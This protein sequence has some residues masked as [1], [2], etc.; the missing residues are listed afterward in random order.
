MVD[1]KYIGLF[2]AMS[3]SLAIGASSIITKMGLN[4]AATQDRAYAS[5]NHA[6]LK[7]GIW[8]TGLSVLANFA[9][10]T[11]A[12]PILVTPLGSISV[13]TGAVL[14]SYILKEELG[15]LGRLGCTLCVIGSLIIVLHA[16]ADKDIQTVDDILRFAKQPGFL[17]YCFTVIVYTVVVLYAFAPTYGRTKPIVYVSISSLFGSVSIMAIKGF[18][19]AVKLT[20]AGNNQ[21]THPST[22]FFAIMMTICIMIQLN[23]INKALDIFSTNIVNT[24]YYVGFSTTTIVASLILFHGFN[25]EDPSTDLSLLAGFIVTFL[26]IHLL[27]VSRQSQSK[28]ALSAYSALESGV[29]VPRVFLHRTSVDRPSTISAVGHAR[30]TSR[31]ST[32][33]AQATLFEALDA[34]D[35]ASAEAIRLRRFSG[36][37]GEDNGFEAANKM[38]WQDHT[39]SPRESMS[40]IDSS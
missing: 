27:E 25:T 14:A 31:Q 16:P 18:G 29:V 28:T 8:W 40:S 20:I 21:F 35:V 30:R 36:E 34:D 9:A 4:D 26:G 5:E 19:I 7:N 3:G 17:F 15:H 23:Y 37:D 12:P 24:M 32:P 33:R 1:D 10:Y 38:V 6:Y 39:D 13:I 11:F 22:Y 2:L